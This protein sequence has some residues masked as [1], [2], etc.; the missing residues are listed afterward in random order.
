LTVTVVFMV[1]PSWWTT[2]QTDRVLSTVL[3]LVKVGFGAVFGAKFTQWQKRR[4]KQDKQRDGIQ[5]LV[6]RVLASPTLND[7][8]I[9]LTKLREFF[10]DECP[11]LLKVEKNLEFFKKW[12]N[13][14]D[15]T[16]QAIGYW[17]VP[18]WMELRE[19]LR[20]LELPK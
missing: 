9:E 19:D 20:N 8:P 15:A 6:L 16:A 5:R 7:V 18:K 1:M 14:T 11:E 10:L 3:D 17:N 12:L 2:A 13:N 4:E